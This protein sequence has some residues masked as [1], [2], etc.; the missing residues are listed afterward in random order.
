[1]LKKR[2]KSTLEMVHGAQNAGENADINQEPPEKRRRR[3][4]EKSEHP[5]YQSRVFI[6]ILLILAACIIS[7]GGVPFVLH[8]ATKTVSVVICKDNLRAGTMITADM[9]DAVEMTSYHLPA[10]AILDPAAAI[11]Q[12]V[13]A[14][15]V[16][17]DIVTK[18]RLSQNYPGND[19]SLLS[20][21]DGKVAISIALSDLAQNVSGKIRG[22]DVIQL[23]AVNS[24]DT[25]GKASAPAE[26][27]YVEVL[28]VSYSDGADVNYDNTV[29]LINGSSNAAGKDVLAAVTVMV[30]PEQ[31]AIIAG[32]QNS[33]KLYAAIVIRGDNGRKSAALLAQE[34]YF[35][36][37]TMTDLATDTEL[38]IPLPEVV[39]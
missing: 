5:F 2:S 39:R 34:N 20:L 33:S 35:A 10:G 15:A 37:A 38:A 18:K 11:G 29:G 14:D 32:L 6:G 17:G 24:N 8:A 36:T 9:L 21:P 12:Y 7:F 23:Y 1:M 3:R 4:A 28:S 31:A 13:T 30:N 19:P 25:S 22:G 26:L 16:E 27:Q